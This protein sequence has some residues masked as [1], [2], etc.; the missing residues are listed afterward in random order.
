M[1]NQVVPSSDEVARQARVKATVGGAR[2]PGV[3]KADLR[4]GTSGEVKTFADMELRLDQISEQVDECLNEI[5]HLSRA[6]RGTER[7]PSFAGKSTPLGRASKISEAFAAWGEADSARSSLMT[8]ADSRQSVLNPPNEESLERQ[9]TEKRA[10]QKSQAFPLEGKRRPLMT[11]ARLFDFKVAWKANRKF[12]SDAARDTTNTKELP[13]DLH[14]PMQ[15]L[16]NSERPFSEKIWELLEDPHS[17]R[18]AWCISFFLKVTTILSVVISNVEIAEMDAQ[19]PIFDAILAAVLETFFDVLFLLEFGSRFL[20]SPIRHRFILDPYNWPDLLSATGV[21]FRASIGFVIKSPATTAEQN[22][23]VILLF[24]FPV[25]RL[26]KLLRYFES[27]RLLVDTC[28]RSF[29]SVPVLLY[30]MAL[31]LL[32]AANCIYL[33]EERSNIPSLGHSHWLALVTMTT[34]GFGDYTPKSSY[35]IT[36]VSLLST[37]STLFLAMPVGIIGREFSISW[38][39]RDRV[40]LLSRLRKCLVKWGYGVK[41]M[42]VLFQYVDANGDG[43]LSLTE[44]IELIYQLRIGFSIDHA[45]DL[46]FLFDD[47]GNGL[48][49][50]QEFLRHVFCDEV[51]EEGFITEE[52]IE[53]SNRRVTQAL[54]FLSV[55]QKRGSEFSEDADLLSG[56]RSQI[57]VIAE[58]SRRE[59]EQ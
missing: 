32:T 47:N 51:L 42:R 4:R 46:F 22:I 50:Y 10:T 31:I 20:T 28:S 53:Q 58:E 13:E 17:S 19:E 45:T 55:H 39:S 52:L 21:F 57:T 48:I 7:L 56:E 11:P 24:I 41:D 3:K 12:N 8:L 37:I 43:S 26:L 18:L 40:I 59:D 25:I 30:T 44:F 54:N 9:R 16:V 15:R 1:L 5:L 2:S 35:G 36:L 38:E 14:L 29:A 33:A 49:D 6:R 27:F 34:V 23:Q